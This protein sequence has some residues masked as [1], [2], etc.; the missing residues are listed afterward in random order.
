MLIPKTWYAII[1]DQLA[2]AKLDEQWLLD[3]IAFDLEKRLEYC[4]GLQAADRLEVAKAARSG[5]AA[6]K[7]TV[8]KARTDADVLLVVRGEMQGEALQVEV[9][10]WQEATQPVKNLCAGGSRAELFSINDVLLKELLDWFR[11][12]GIGIA[13]I[14]TSKYLQLHPAQNVANYKFL[15]LGILALH[16]GELEAARGYLQEVIAAEPD[17]WW[18]YYFSGA[19]EFHADNFQQAIASCHKAL[20]IDPDRYAAIYAN[21]AACYRSM[22]N[23]RMA[24]WAEEAFAC[25][26][27]MR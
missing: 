23:P 12:I 3:G 20:E 27:E 26:K 2:N 6:A 18:G 4:K 16:R 17:N 19:V 8:V 1:K 9:A 14:S 7:V 22:G 15:I 13:D 5:E 10:V 21:L 11:N 24:Q 25:C